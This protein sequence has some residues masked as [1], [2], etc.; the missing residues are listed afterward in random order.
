MSRSRQ[1]IWNDL[2]RIGAQI[3]PECG[4]IY[5]LIYRSVFLEMDRAMTPTWWEKFVARV[6]RYLGRRL[7]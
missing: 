4:D 5:V 1:Q 7:Q 3:T 6:E 2:M